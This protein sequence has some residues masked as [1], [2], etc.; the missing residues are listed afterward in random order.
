M[1][2]K[3]TKEPPPAIAFI[4]PASRPAAASKGRC[5]IAG[6]VRAGAGSGNPQ[7]FGA[8][9]CIDISPATRT[10]VRDLTRACGF[11]TVPPIQNNA[12]K[13]G[14]YHDQAVPRAV[15]RA[16]RARQCRPRRHAGERTALFQRAPREVFWTARDIAQ[17]M[18]ELGYYALWTAEHHFQREGYECLPNLVQ[19]GLWLATQTQAPEVRLRV[20]RAADVAPDPAGRGLRDGRHRHRR[21]GDH[22][23]RPRLSHARGGDVRRV[24]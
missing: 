12:A 8:G 24:R 7:W 16:D 21:A 10:G 23:R 6:R 11:R 19:L 20:Q 17:L 1:A 22:G 15:C 9:R 2:G 5:C 4:A 14:A 3:L 18:D 13:G